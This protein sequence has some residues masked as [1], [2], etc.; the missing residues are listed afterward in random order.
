MQIMMMVVII[1]TPRRELLAHCLRSQWLWHNSPVG[2]LL[3][4]LGSAKLHMDGGNVNFLCKAYAKHL[5]DGMCS[6]DIYHL[7]QWNLML[8]VFVI[9]MTTI[10][11]K[12]PS[13]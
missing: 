3:A 10:I 4:C 7:F 9:I 8:M 1:I 13:S 6:I 12:A 2:Q 5:H 11:I